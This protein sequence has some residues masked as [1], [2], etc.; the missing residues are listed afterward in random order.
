MR[1]LTGVFAGNGLGAVE[2]GGPTLS[3]CLGAGVASTTRRVFDGDLM[4]KGR[5]VGLPGGV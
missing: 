1:R 5:R 4:G 2:G 3:F